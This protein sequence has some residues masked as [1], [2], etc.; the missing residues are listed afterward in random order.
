MYGERSLKIRSLTD[1]AA[2]P[3]A[4]AAAA[5]VVGAAAAPAA[6]QAPIT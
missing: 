3:K 5:P 4:D 1:A 6:P 2:A